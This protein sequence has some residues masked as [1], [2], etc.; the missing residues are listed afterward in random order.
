M[1]EGSYAA[2]AAGAD[3]LVLV[4][5]E[6]VRVVALHDAQ[7]IE[8]VRACK[9]IE[10]IIGAFGGDKNLPGDE[11]HILAARTKIIRVLVAERVLANGGGRR[12]AGV[13]VDVGVIRVG[14]RNIKLAAGR[15]GFAERCRYV[16]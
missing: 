8:P 4:V 13:N 12:E 10:K 9:V 16:L 6:L 7:A 5:G 14:K 15:I 1:V 11:A 2:T 3:P